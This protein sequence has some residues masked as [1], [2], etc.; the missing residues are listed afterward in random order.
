MLLCV[1]LDTFD[2]NTWKRIKHHLFFIFISPDLLRIFWTYLHTT[3]HSI[4]KMFICIR[5]L[6]NVHAR[7]LHVSWWSQVDSCHIMM[8]WRRGTKK[9]VVNNHCHETATKHIIRKSILVSVIQYEYFTKPYVFR[10]KMYTHTIFVQWQLY[11]EIYT[12][13]RSVYQVYIFTHS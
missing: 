2:I 9:R 3:L 4:W 12:I 10:Q 8:S 5:Y 6:K 11:M 13:S 1:I 7:T